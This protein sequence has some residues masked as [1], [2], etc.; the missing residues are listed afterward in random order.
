MEVTGLDREIQA[1]ERLLPAI[2][3]SHGSGWALVANCALVDTFTSFASAVRYARANYGTQEVL[4]RHTDE[5]VEE[6]APF[7]HVHAD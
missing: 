5:R 3:Q 7:L 6:T 4:I 2:R 1:Y